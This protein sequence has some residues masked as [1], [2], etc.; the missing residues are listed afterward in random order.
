MKYLA[1][2]K[3]RSEGKSKLKV[4]RGPWRIQPQFVRA[5]MWG[6]S[7]VLLPVVAAFVL[8]YLVHIAAQIFF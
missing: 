6:A 2:L 8:V 1:Q 4:S 5:M 3:H 7:S